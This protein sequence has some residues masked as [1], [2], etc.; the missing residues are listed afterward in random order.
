M[1]E[2]IACLIVLLQLY[3]GMIT[4]TFIFLPSVVCYLISHLN[5]KP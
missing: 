4:N 1:P 5:D 2:S 3:A